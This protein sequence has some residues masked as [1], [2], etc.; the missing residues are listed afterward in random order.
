MFDVIKD[1]I[2]AKF[3]K[4]KNVLPFSSVKSFFG[5]D[6]FPAWLRRLAFKKKTLGRSLTKQRREEGGDG[7][8]D[9][10]ERG[11]RDERWGGG[12]GGA[13]GEVGLWQIFYL[14]AKAG[15]RNPKVQRGTVAPAPVPG[16]PSPL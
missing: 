2:R 8:E 5:P 16:R 12:G 3:K 15:E 9:E 1:L 13:G 6:Y 7:E 10:Q 11:G 14:K 4:L